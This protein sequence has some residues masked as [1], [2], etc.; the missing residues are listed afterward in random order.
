MSL[1][2]QGSD[3]E[4][5]VGT[6]APVWLSMPRVADARERF[7]VSVSVC[8]LD[9]ADGLRSVDVVEFAHYR[10]DRYSLVIMTPGEA[11]DL[12]RSL[13]QAADKC[14]PCAGT[15]ESAGRLPLNPDKPAG[16]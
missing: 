8:E 15:R 10:D 4:I 7:E 3:R 14:P 11:R 5:G 6:L 12:A 13:V 2:S 16:E 9:L 1:N